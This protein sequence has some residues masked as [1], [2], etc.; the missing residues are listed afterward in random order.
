MCDVLWSILFVT[1]DRGNRNT[2]AGSVLSISGW[3]RRTVAIVGVAALGG[4]A[5]WYFANPLPPISHRT[6]RIGWE[7]VPPVQIRTSDGYAGLAVD[8]IREAAKRAHIKLEWVETGTSSD[9]AFQKGLV[10]LWP[11]MADLPD[12]RKRVHFTRPWLHSG[13]TMLV[14]AGS[15]VP[16]KEFAGRIAIF[17][18]PL[19][20]RLLRE[21]YPSAQVVP[22]TELSAVLKAVCSDAAAGAYMEL[23]AAMNALRDKP[24][25]CA[26]VDLRAHMVPDQTLQLAIASTFESA[27]AAELLRSEITGLFRD[28][29][30]AVNMSKYSYYGLDDTW[31]T[32]EL[33]IGS[34]VLALGVLLWRIVS[35]R[36]RR[37]ADAILRESEERFR[38]IFQQAAVGVAQ[39]N[40]DGELVMVNDRYCEVLGRTREELLG[41][42]LVDS[43]HPD[44]RAAI[45]AERQRLLA[46]DA[47]SCD[48]DAR[49]IRKDGAIVWIRLYGSLVRDTQSRPKYLIVVIEDIT[50][51]KRAEEALRESEAR[52]RNMADTAPVMIWVT[53]TDKLCTFFNK[54]WLDFTGRT[55]EQESGYGWV[56]GVHPE[57][58]ESCAATYSSAFDT[59][60]SFQMEQRL[61]RADGEYRSLLCTGIPRFT[62]SGTFAGYVGCS[63]DITDLKRGQEQVLATQK[64]ESLGVMAGGIA[65][66][67]NNLLGGIVTTSELVLEEIPAG[68]AGR[69]G[70]EGIKAVALRAAGI[71]RELMAYSGKEDAAFEPV[72]VSRLVGE[73]LQFLKVTIS[74]QAILNV[75]L[76][77]GLPAVWANPAQI[78]QVVMNLI[79]NASEALG[80]RVGVIAVRATHVT[81]ARDGA[82]HILLEVGDTG[83]GMTPEIQAKIFDPFFTTKFTGRGLGL[84]AA[85]GII[86]R[87]GG[88]IRVTSQP[89]RGSR[90]EILLPC[91]DEPAERGVGAAASAAPV[92]GTCFV[93]EDEDAL[94]DAVSRMLRKRGLT[95]IEAVDGRVA[96]E[97]FRDM[98]SEIDVVLLDMTLPGMSGREVFDA[99]QEIRPGVKVVITTA[100]SQ[101]TALTSL[102]GQRAL[103]Y[104]QKPYQFSDLFALL[105]ETLSET[106][107]DTCRPN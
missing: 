57:D 14:R 51:R 7:N 42:L 102:G 8:T 22:F 72:D 34:L 76:P 16:E 33:A 37:R 88:A 107:R 83:S 67:F 5:Y 99:M 43:A 46:G 45:L 32:Y 69:E 15:P 106:L 21:E 63:L 71:V 98:A 27:G 61:R 17:R 73:M 12:R 24:A 44:E 52:F 6:L 91:T 104:I 94:R 86:R 60:R 19:H 25:E 64:L 26:A 58:R 77:E 56:E 1:G 81:E 68:A 74:K 90:F 47:S 96:I 79:T 53:D 103:A 3:L 97:L 93:V 48:L 11:L 100:Y 4:L 39:V 66:D 28:G 18:M 95:V 49:C 70:I 50:E 80:E 87:H 20:M 9:E 84:A 40:L 101:E 62:E 55:L 38:A 85:Q 78:R 65:H 36:Q 10:D 105:R 23:R 2:G 31:A 89:G 92:A 75:D 54:G 59:R 13:H 41:H 30:M 29:T 35:S 82:G